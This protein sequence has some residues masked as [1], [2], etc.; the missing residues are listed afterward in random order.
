MKNNMIN[1]NE[2]GTQN[3]HTWKAPLCFS[4]LVVILLPY[5][6]SPLPKTKKHQKK[7]ILRLLWCLLFVS[8][9]SLFLIFYWF[10]LSPFQ[11]TSPAQEKMLILY[12]F[13]LSN[14]ES[15]WTSSVTPTNLKKMRISFAHN[16][17][18]TSYLET[19]CR[20]TIPQ[21]P[22]KVSSLLFSL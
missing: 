14:R 19:S 17:L 20:E 4:S 11:Q 16:F 6:P 12:W 2:Q 22:K 21:L 9:D 5:S 10:F 15:H 8:F 13:S 1:E 18:Q 7:D 3:I